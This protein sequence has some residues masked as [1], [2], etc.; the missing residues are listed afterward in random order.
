VISNYEKQN[1]QELF[2]S[3]HKENNKA[4]IYLKLVMQRVVK[5]SSG[6]TDILNT[7]TALRRHL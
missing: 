6:I 4:Y 2:I 1:R 7:L 3:E 5:V